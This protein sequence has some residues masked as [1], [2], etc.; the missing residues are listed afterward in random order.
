MQTKRTPRRA[1]V[2]LKP[3]R[4]TP[5][6]LLALI[7]I[8][9]IG[10]CLVV[11]ALFDHVI[12]QPDRKVTSNVRTST[13]APAQSSE[14]PAPLSGGT[15]AQASGEPAS[16]TAEPPAA[17]AVVGDFSAKFADK[18]TSGEI[19]Q[20]DTSYVSANVNITLSTYRDEDSGSTCFIQDIYVRSIDCLRTAFAR[21][22]FGKAITED[23]LVMAANNNAIAAINSD[24]YGYGNAGVVIRNGELFRSDYEDGEQV[25][26]IF[27]DGTMRLYHDSSELD[28]DA[29]MAEGAWQSFSF[30]PGL[31]DGN[32]NLVDTY[33]RVNHDPRTVIAM[34]EPG[35]YMFIVVDGRRSSY[36]NGM[37]YRELAV[38]C[39]NLGCTMAYNL[40]G[41]RTSQMTFLGTMTNLPYKDGRPTSDIVYITDW[42]G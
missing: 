40:D 14:T 9:L 6:L 7:D 17:P 35:H 16:P 15:D 23:V 5:P 42:A 18:F 25:L 1:P 31:L 29:A 2:R 41:G 30:G 26:I 20:T 11:F 27:R 39:Q 4:Q 38:L 22:T 37:T 12:P 3:P 28:I 13:Q 24:Y 32:G 19:L 8:L 10:V 21:D 34:V 33:E 36:S